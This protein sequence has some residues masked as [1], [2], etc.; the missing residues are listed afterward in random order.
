MTYF[1]GSTLIV[2]T[3]LNRQLGIA[4]PLAFALSLILKN[5]FTREIIVRAIFPFALSISALF[6]F[7]QWLTATGQL[8]AL[9][10]VK[11]DALVTA[12]TNPNVLLDFGKNVFTALLY[13]GWFLLPVSAFIFGPM[14]FRF[15]TKAPTRLLLPISASVVTI[16]LGLILCYKNPHLMPL[17]GNIIDKAGIGPLTLRDIFFLNAPHLALPASFW[18]IITGF[19]L[20]GG[21]C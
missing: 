11:R 8:P 21:H 10:N 1:V 16:L 14:W 7:E 2:I 3:T 18:L 9:Y 6:I 15:N 13:L 4:I 5:G 17:S 20:I 19:S 12:L